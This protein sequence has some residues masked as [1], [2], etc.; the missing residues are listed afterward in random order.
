M[1]FLIYGTDK[2]K[3]HEFLE[4]LMARFLKGKN[5]FSLHRLDEESFS[6]SVFNGLLKTDSLFLN[7][8][9]VVA[10]R[11]FQNFA[12]A[13]YILSNLE[14]LG[15]SGNVFVFWE[16]KI[17]DDFLKKIKK[18]AEVKKFDSAARPDFKKKKED[19]ELFKVA[20]LVALRK[21]QE[22]WFLYQ[23]I[24]MKG[25]PC[26]EVF[27]KILWQMKVLGLIKRGGGRKLHPF[28]L[29]KAKRAA[30]LFQEKELD[31]FLGELVQIYHDYRN[32]TADLAVGL[33]RFI[34][35]V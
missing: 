15:S 32:G 5:F 9:L 12:A 31:G 3:S 11:L 21:K 17:K 22:A 1:I 30:G 14:I 16:E 29:A 13:D 25:G 28:V 27:W 18:Y 2:D 35:R 19:E 6:E 24:I 26:E 34:L 10:K 7:K 20:D 4:R 33:E 8:N 23:R